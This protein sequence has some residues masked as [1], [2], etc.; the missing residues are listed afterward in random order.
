MDLVLNLLATIV[1]TLILCGQLFWFLFHAFLSTWRSISFRLAYGLILFPVI[2]LATSI[3]TFRE[4]LLAVHYA[5]H[6]LL[7]ILG[8]CCYGANAWLYRLS[9]PFLPP[10]RL[11]GKHALEPQQGEL[12][13]R[14]IFSATRNPRYLSAW[15]FVLAMALIT[16]YLALYLLFFWSLLGF[17][18]ITLLEERELRERFGETYSL[19][20]RTVPR[21]WPNWRRLAESQ[22]AARAM[23]SDKKKPS[24]R[25]HVQEEGQT[26]NRFMCLN[27]PVLLLAWKRKIW[28]LVLSGPGL[29]DP[30]GN[31]LQNVNT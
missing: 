27:D 13:T 7:I 10:H 24:S 30:A 19:Y 9:R 21:Y 31:S 17:H 29:F 22:A 2:A 16:N 4:S 6:P 20:C 23:T 8:L 1:L 14:G 26:E 5:P 3:L 12:Q 15:L 11:L 28:S 18:L 25:S